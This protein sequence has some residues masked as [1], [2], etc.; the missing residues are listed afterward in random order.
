MCRGRKLPCPRRYPAEKGCDGLCLLCQRDRPTW[1]AN[2]D[3]HMLQERAACGT[4]SKLPSLGSALHPGRCRPCG[5]FH[6]KKSGCS[7]GEKCFHCHS[8][9]PDEQK[10]RRKDKLAKVREEEK[11]LHEAELCNAPWR[12]CTAGGKAAS[13]GMQPAMMP[14]VQPIVF[15]MPCGYPASTS[16]APTKRGR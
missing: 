9:Q 1:W 12:H 5:F 11:V 7:H 8:C 6:G 14:I 15:W 4:L 10:T 16:Q 2:E 3:E 13:I